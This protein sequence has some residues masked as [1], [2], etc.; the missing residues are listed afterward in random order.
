MLSEWSFMGFLT[1]PLF[2]PVFLALML[3]WGIRRIMSHFG[4]Y[5]F[6]WQPVLADIA[7]FTLLLWAVLAVSGALPIGEGA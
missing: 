7:L 2:V 1:P 3:F 4:L 6:L 5:R